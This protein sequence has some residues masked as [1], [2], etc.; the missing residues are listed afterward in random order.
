MLDALLVNG[1][2]FHRILVTFLQFQANLRGATPLSAPGP[3]TLQAF[4][5][6]APA[7]V[8]DRPIG[9]TAGATVE[10]DAKERE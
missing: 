6:T 10:G 2:Y 5:N 9:W 8:Q 1:E 7:A 3:L 4:L